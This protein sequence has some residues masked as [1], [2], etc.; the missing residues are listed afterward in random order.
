MK[1]SKIIIISLST[2]IT[3]ALAGCGGGGGGGGN[4]NNIWTWLF[5]SNTIDQIGT[6]GTKGVPDVANVP[7]A[8]NGAVSWAISN[9]DFYLFGGKG[10]DETGA[11][12]GELN[13][14]WRFDGFRWTWISGAS[15]ALE[16]GVYG[17]QGTPDANNVPGARFLSASWR[18]SNDNLWL[19]GGSGEDDFSNAGYL[20]DLW[21]FDG[22]EWTWISGSNLRD[23]LGIYGI[24]GIPDANNVPGARQGAAAWID[25]NDNLWL[26]GGFGYD[27]LGNLR[28]L[29]DLWRFDGT[30][31]TWISGSNTGNQTGVYG[32]KGAANPANV[33]GARQNSISWIDAG[34]NLW[35]FGGEGFGSVGF[36]FLNGLWRFDG[37]Q[38]TWVSGSNI[39]DQ[40]GIYGTQGTPDANNVPG[41][42][43]QA[44]AWIDGNN[45]IRLFGGQ[46]YDS[47]NTGLLNDIWRFDGGEWTWLS[48]SNTVDQPG[49]YGVLGIK[50]TRN[51]PGA[52]RGT[53]A[54][55]EL[56]GNLW[57]FGGFGYDS[58]GN[59]SNIND[60]WELDE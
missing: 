38:W 29:N 19:F 41:A 20:N 5:G 50:N 27:S 42:R 58:N 7:G 45:N 21:R 12:V 59:L 18:D 30:E 51:V 52:R 55:I 53:V 46:G 36:G 39:V 47:A 26:F 37:N 16:A 11:F 54:S 8:R 25:S 15:T 56:N 31:W 34:D 13:D 22:N 24:Q 40:P 48:G 10:L 6:Y 1:L 44:V 43:E 60:L 17:I 23:Q 32:T 3:L 14:L 35:L 2:W 9:G 57:L 4:A 28:W 49:N 33:P